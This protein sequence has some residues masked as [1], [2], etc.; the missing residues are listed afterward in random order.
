M[1]RSR[2]PSIEPSLADT[3]R[4]RALPGPP[5]LRPGN[6]RLILCEDGAYL[7][8]FAEMCN[9]WITHTLSIGSWQNSESGSLKDSI[10]IPSNVTRLSR[11][12]KAVSSDGIPQVVNY[13]WGVGGGGGLA[14]KLLGIGGGGSSCLRL[15]LKTSDH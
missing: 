11:A 1:S 5:R 15:L 9:R 4:S 12:I 10:V 3:H 13:H 6:K 14:D 7:R 2:A 8:P